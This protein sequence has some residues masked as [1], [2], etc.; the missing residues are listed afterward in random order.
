MVSLRRA[1]LQGRRLLVLLTRKARRVLSA[2]RTIYVDER[3]QEYRGYWA[4]AAQRIGA[5]IRDLSDRAWE[6]RRGGR[7]TRICISHVQMN[8]P[9]VSDLS[10]DKAYCYK[11][12]SAAGVPVA[13]HATFA[14]DALRQAVEF[15]EQRKGLYVVKPA[16][17]TSAGIGVTTHVKTR[18]QLERAA[19]LASAFNP[20]FLV[21]EMIPGESCRL[22]YIG[23]ELVH[24]VRRRGLRVVGSEGSTVSQLVQKAG[25][26][27]SLLDANALWTL[28]AQGLTPASAIAEGCEVLV[29]SLPPGVTR[30]RELRTVYTETI[31][32]LV[33]PRLREEIGRVVAAIECELAG[34]DVITFD[35]SRS[36][37]ET[38][39]VFLEVNPAPGLHHHYISPGD[40]QNHPVTV[41]LLEYLLRQR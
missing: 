3:V 7:H 37:L 26:N 39:G 15:C 28:Q 16:D 5:E 18:G 1:W 27:R 14:L 23:G 35:P 20:T 30:Q 2:E 13:R 11:L 17:N 31:T 24:G 21:E 25:L 40:H 12:A 8:D 33:G 36:L 32:E 4:G 10:S 22:L 34:V 41:R 19:L 6:V 38:G 9:V 29:R